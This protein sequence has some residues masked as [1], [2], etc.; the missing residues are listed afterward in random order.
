MSVKIISTEERKRARIAADPDAKIAPKL[1][2][3]SMCRAAHR[4]PVGVSCDRYSGS[5]RFQDLA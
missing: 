1:P 3:T 4:C 5:H 2:R